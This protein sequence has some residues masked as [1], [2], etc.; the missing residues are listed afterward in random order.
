MYTG[1]S[2]VLFGVVEEEGRMFQKLNEDV[3]ILREGFFTTL[4]PLGS[5]RPCAPVH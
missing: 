5:W 2:W 4:M 3:S 1:T